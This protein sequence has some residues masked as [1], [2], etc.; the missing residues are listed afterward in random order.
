MR[1]GASTGICGRFVWFWPFWGYGGGDL[2]GELCE[3]WEREVGNEIIPTVSRSRKL[4]V[5]R[6]DRVC[7]KYAKLTGASRRWVLQDRC[8]RDV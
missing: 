7:K 8:G 2:E 6:Y 1:L 4:V 5:S 3:C